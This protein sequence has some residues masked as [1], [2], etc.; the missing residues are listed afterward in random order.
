MPGHFFARVR[1]KKRI[2]FI[3]CFHG[4]Q[5]I[6]EKDIR[7]NGVIDPDELHRILHTPVN[8]DAI[9]CRIMRNMIN[10]Y[11][12]TGETLSSR[13]MEDLISDFEDYLRDY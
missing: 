9:I 4:G 6:E 12:Q 10:A 11:R 13:L 1:L 5:I 3:D 7:Y 8:A 2:F